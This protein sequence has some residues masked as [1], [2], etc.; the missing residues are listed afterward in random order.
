MTVNV[1]GFTVYRSGWTG[2]CTL[3]ISGGAYPDIVPTP[4]AHTSAL[5]YAEEIM[6]LANYAWSSTGFGVTVDTSGKIVLSGDVGFSLAF[7]GNAGTRMGFGAGSGTATSHT[8]GSVGDGCVFPY[9]RDA[10]WYTLDVPSP[11]RAGFLVQGHA[12]MQHTPGLAWKQPE[13]R[14]TGL[15]SVVLGVVDAMQYADTPAKATLLVDPSTLVTLHVGKVRSSTLDSM[16]GWG[17][18]DFEVAL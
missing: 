5:Q 6:D 10:M 2:G 9:A 14:I 16:S 1:R 13:A 3:A 8:A 11:G 12:I 18:V 15:R 7:T 17:S 4:T